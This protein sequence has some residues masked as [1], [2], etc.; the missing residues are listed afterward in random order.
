M[1]TSGCPH[2]Q[3]RLIYI[4]ALPPRSVVK[5]C[6]PN[7]LSSD[8]SPSATVSIGKAKTTNSIEPSAV[9]VN[10]GMRLSVM[11]GARRRI[12]V[13]IK[14]MPDSRVPRPAICRAQM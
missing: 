13:T 9:Q 7:T 2:A 11:P 5:K 10:I 3:I 8:K 6:I 4:I 14:F 1:Y 12:M